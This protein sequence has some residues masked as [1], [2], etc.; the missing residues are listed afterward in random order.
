MQHA[1]SDPMGRGIHLGRMVLASS[2]AGSRWRLLMMHEE[3]SAISRAFRRSSSLLHCNRPFR[4]SKSCPS[5]PNR[6][7]FTKMAPIAVSDLS[8]PP[9]TS[10]LT[11]QSAP[12]I[13]RYDANSLD[14]T[15]DLLVSVIER[16]G[17][18]IVENIISKDLAAQIKAELKPYFDTEYVAS[19]P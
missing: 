16:D 6:Q 15:T 8:Q 14:T 5:L 3:V 18:V 17:G 12:S 2:S 9:I 19:T 7:C 4:H 1:L 13:A 10:K 11:A